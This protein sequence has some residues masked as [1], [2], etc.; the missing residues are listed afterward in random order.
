MHTTKPIGRLSR[1]K[2]DNSTAPNR[3]GTIIKKDKRLLLYTY[4][5]SRE[6]VQFF[7]YKETLK[8]V[9]NHFP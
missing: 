1:E 2:K 9:R 3:N 6:R 5:A 8:E 4:T 7:L